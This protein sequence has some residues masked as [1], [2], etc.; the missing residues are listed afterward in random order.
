MSERRIPKQ[1]RLDAELFVP[2]KED[3]IPPRTRDETEAAERHGVRPGTL[4]LKQ[5]TR[6]L[7]IARRMVDIE[8]TFGPAPKANNFMTR[9]LGMAFLGSA[10]YTYA[11]DSEIMDRNLTIPR[12]FIENEVKE[13][14]IG[15][16]KAELDTPRIENE[17]YEKSDIDALA[18]T[19]T[20]DIEEDDQDG[21][22]YNFVEADTPL[23]YEALGHIDKAIILSRNFAGAYADYRNKP[24]MSF[25]LGRELAQSALALGLIGTVADVNGM[26]EYDAQKFARKHLTAM[27]RDA[28]T[29]ATIPQEGSLD[30]MGRYPS[31]SQLPDPASHFRIFWKRNAPDGADEVLQTALSKPY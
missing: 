16:G 30:S 2:G 29:I 1:F 12:R 20:Q 17:V 8:A 23:I 13:E 27:A 22:D 11:R 3:Y 9:Y 25:N 14:V 21:I 26:D 6:G 7:V 5:E 15:E 28:K 4:V 10:Y 19:E 18:D 24:E 31:L